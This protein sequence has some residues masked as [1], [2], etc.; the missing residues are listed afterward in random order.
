MPPA[1]DARIDLPKLAANAG[2][3]KPVLAPDFKPTAAQEIQLTRIIQQIVAAWNVALREEIMPAYRNQLERRSGGLTIGVINGGVEEIEAALNRATQSTAARVVSSEPQLTAFAAE[4]ATWHTARFASAIRAATRV[5]VSSLISASDAD[6]LLRGA[7]RRNVALIKGLD[8]EIS[9]K[10][11]LAVFEAWNKNDSA[12]KLTK[13]LREDLGFAPARA[14]LIGQDQIGKLAG[15]LERFRHADLNIKKFV[16]HR[17]E[18]LSPRPEHL[19]LVGNI[20]EWS[21]PPGGVIPGQLINCKCR[22]RAY[23]EPKAA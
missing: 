2:L 5:D 19:A 15:E 23:V 3:K 11:E 6:D 10:V 18:S 12:K 1:D 7:V 4:F 9:K 13:T 8:A 21:D 14:K 20:Y 22:A 17:T 16:W